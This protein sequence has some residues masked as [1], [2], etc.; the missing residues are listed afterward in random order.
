MLKLNYYYYLL[1][2][3]VIVECKLIQDN[4]FQFS[5]EHVGYYDFST[6][7]NSKYRDKIIDA[8]YVSS[9]ESYED[10]GELELDFILG[11]MIRKYDIGYSSIRDMLHSERLVL[12]GY[13]LS[14]LLKGLDKQG[15][16]IKFDVDKLENAGFL[17]DND[18]GRLVNINWFCKELDSRL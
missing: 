9:K 18:I 5:S 3:V 6:L 15:G 10:S 11:D 12:D 8:L 7:N 14:Y 1:I 2:I 4:D 16:T 17:R 13:A